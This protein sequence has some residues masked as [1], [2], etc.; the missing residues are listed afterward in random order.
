[1]HTAYFVYASN[2]KLQALLVGMTENPKFP[3]NN[4]IVSNHLG[5]ALGHDSQARVNFLATNLLLM[6]F[7]TYLHFQ[8]GRLAYIL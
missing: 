8:R 2:L 4:R 5:N 1:M 6:P 7:E 3:T